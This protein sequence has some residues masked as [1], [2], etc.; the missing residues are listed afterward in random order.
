MNLGTQK[1]S[2]KQLEL[3]LLDQE[4]PCLEKEAKIKIEKC[5]QVVEKMTGQDAEVVYGVNTGFGSL[6]D[7][8]VD[9]KNLSELQMN[10]IRSHSV[11]VGRPLSTPVVRLMML[12]RA[13]TLALGHSGV[14]CSTI[15]LLLQMLYHRIHPVIPSKGSVGASGDLAPLSHLALCLVGEGQVEYQS[16]IMSTQRAFEKTGLK[17]LAP[18]P[19]EAL[20]LINGTQ[21]MTAQASLNWIQARHIVWASHL[22]CALSL[23]ATLGSEKAFDP[24]VHALKPHPGQLRVATFMTKL[25][26]GSEMMHSHANCNKVQDAYSFRCA[27]QVHGVAE[28]ALERTRQTLEIEM[29]SVTDNPL[30]F[31]NESLF[32]SAGHFH[33]QAV[34]FAMDAL[35]MALTSLGSISERRT[36]RLLHS[37]LSELPT[38]LVKNAGLQSGLMMLQVTSAALVSECKVLSHPSSV[39]S[40]PTWMDQE[41][42]VSMGAHASQKNAEV[43]QNLARIVAIEL[44]CA[45]QA[46]HF[47]R[48]LKT[49]ATL[50]C[51]IDEIRKISSAVDHDR[52]LSTDI[53]SVAA[54]LLEGGFND[55]IPSN[56]EEMTL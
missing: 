39:D 42:H 5:F 44:L 29:N 41:D 28:E 10:L 45:A 15:D 31:P 33:G 40:I 2:L 54:F 3:F 53:E 47:R 51:A 25:L 43:V 49:S 4:E 23:E 26:E 18:K 56:T 6:K 14:A 35:T 55:W 21:M 36:F 1:L 46:F 32:V 30:I 13:H 17:P 20:A 34:S 22:A 8:R 37:G 48:P 27:P 50:E 19:K 52:A 9:S 38:A 12:L 16:K 24:K 7:V 11:G